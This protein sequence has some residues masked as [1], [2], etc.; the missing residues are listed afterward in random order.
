MPQ[1]SSSIPPTPTINDI[2][3][4]PHSGPTFENFCRI[5]TCSYHYGSDDFSPMMKP[6]S[7][8]LSFTETTSTNSSSYHSYLTSSRPLAGAG[9]VTYAPPCS[10]PPTAYISIGSVVP[11]SP[12]QSQHL[13]LNSTKVLGTNSTFSALCH[14]TTN[15]ILF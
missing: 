11:I 10:S 15:L 14:D 12:S 5:T 3:Q 1:L 9:A 7:S 4:S 6:Y 13:P 8:M 2:D